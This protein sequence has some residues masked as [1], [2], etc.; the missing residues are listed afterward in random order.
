MPFRTCLLLVTLFITTA[1][2]GDTLHPCE[3]HTLTFTA[4]GTYSNPYTDIPVEN[5]DDL[6]VVTF[7]GTA[8]EASNLE[9]IF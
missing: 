6:L 5:R 2:H 9:K 7:T 8:G 1:S 3:V 4:R